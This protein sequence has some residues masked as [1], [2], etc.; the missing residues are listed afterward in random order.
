[1]KVKKGLKDFIKKNME[2]MVQPSGFRSLDVLPERLMLMTL[3]EISF[4][5]RLNEFY[6]SKTCSRMKIYP[7]LKPGLAV[8]LVCG[9]RYLIVSTP[10]DVDFDDKFSYRMLGLTETL[11][12]CMFGPD[13]RIKPSYARLS[14]KIRDISK[15]YRV[16]NYN[17]GMTILLG[18]DS[19]DYSLIE[20]WKR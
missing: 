16:D 17:P 19:V 12:T 14:S 2:F 18:K 20:I 15:V 8:D 3:K 11:N 9:E 5:A 1:M 4:A 7:E 10:I 13:L 6:Q